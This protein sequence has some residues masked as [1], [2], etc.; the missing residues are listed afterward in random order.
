MAESQLLKT[1]DG[2]DLALEYVEVPAA[3]KA[4]IFA[5]GMTVSRTD[6][7]ICVRSA[8]IL[9]D[10]GISTMRFDFR[11]HGESSGL[12]EKDFTISGE[13]IDL[14][15]IFDWVKKDGFEKI[16]LAGASFGGAIAS[17]FAGE[18]AAEIDR[19]ALINPVLNFDHCFLHPRLPWGKKYLTKYQESLAKKSLCSGW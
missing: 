5:H 1:P 9:N 6:E 17:L 11:A 2:F 4:V 12:P 14:T 19:L 15:V 3:T 8:K 10:L 16:G 18:H 7:G 13:L